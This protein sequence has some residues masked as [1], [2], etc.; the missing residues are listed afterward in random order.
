MSG[1]TFS[2]NSAIVN[3]LSPAC[4]TSIVGQLLVV[5]KKIGRRQPD[6]AQMLF[7]GKKYN[8]AQPYKRPA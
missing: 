7:V 6:V 8:M 1:C 5:K 3:S 4:T 2:V